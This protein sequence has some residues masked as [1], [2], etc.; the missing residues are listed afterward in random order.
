ML[1][2]KSCDI[3]DTCATEHHALHG[4]MLQYTTT[5]GHS[6]VIFE[7]KSLQ[8]IIRHDCL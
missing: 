3:A 7:K 4:D 5:A 8:K 2:H 6:A 1:L